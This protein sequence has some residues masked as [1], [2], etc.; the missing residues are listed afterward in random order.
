MKRCL[1]FL[2]CAIA[3]CAL[4][5]ELPRRSQ[6]GFGLQ[7]L[8]AE[9][10]SKLKIEQGTGFMVSPPSG[11]S[12]PGTIA[13]GDIVIAFDG[14]RFQNNTE[15]NLILREL[16]AGREV[17]VTVLDSNGSTTTR[18]FT[19]VERPKDK[20]ENY[21][22]S[23]GHIVSNGKRMRTLISRP[24]GFPGKRPVLFWLPGITAT[25]IDIPLSNSWSVSQI[26]KSFN[27]DGWV[28]V[29]VDKPG[30]GD[31]EGGPAM[32]VAYDEE[33]DIYRQTLKSLSNHAFI[34]RDRVFL[35]GHSMG[36]CHAPIIA[37]EQPVRGIITYGTVSDSWLE[38]QIK[39][40]RS[41]GLLGGASPADIDRRVRQTVAFYSALYNDKKSIEQIVKENPSLANY[42]KGA[43]ADGINL[44]ARS[45][46]Y[47]VELNDKNFGDYW[48]KVGDS[49]V[50]ALFGEHDF[51]ALEGDQTQ[52]A[53]FVN[54]VKPGNG[55][56]EKVT[57]SDHGFSTTSSFADSLS[58]WGKPGAVFNPNIISQMKEW[59]KKVESNQ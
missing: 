53:S 13:T 18:R 4:A 31:S 44:S 48:S 41:Q 29:R 25:S 8:T 20:G 54:R 21:E 30:T 59:I 11:G 45:I 3:V 15:L 56:F 9:T 50:L 26:L 33:V 22:V 32:A 42:A 49:K 2:F 23:Y 16:P 34:N 38:W 27:D 36:G 17:T 5:Q 12:L 40:E 37:S 39:A 46:K 14:K 10:L 6:L 58:K 24:N 51:V 7:P 55:T 35:F 52:V 47:M 1:S 57:G 28:T 43:S 19:P